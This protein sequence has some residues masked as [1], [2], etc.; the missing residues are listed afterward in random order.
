MNWFYAIDQQQLG[1]I[2]QEEFS[3]LLN[4]GIIKSDTMVWREGMANWLPY[5]EYAAS[6]SVPIP[7]A[8]PVAVSTQYATNDDTAVC[9]VS[10]KIYPKREMV[11]YEGKW[12]SAEHRDAFFQRLREGVA[13]P[14]NMIYCGFWRRFF[15]KLIDFVIGFALGT[16]NS[17]ICSLLIFG[18]AQFFMPRAPAGMGGRTMLFTGISMFTGQAIALLYAWFFISKFQATPGK[19]ALNMKIVRADGARLS[20]GRII[21]RY[22]AEW[23][24]GFTI[25][26]TY[27]MVGVDLPEHRGLHDRIC[28]TRVVRR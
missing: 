8:K 18:T 1:P 15:A 21:G 7:I 26:L 5:S 10:G 28:D 12:I 25:G 6:Q 16:I 14:G 13:Q 17:A 3:R 23:I 9:A 27:I 20:T 22:F 24:N 4:D 19:L 11:Q 2:T